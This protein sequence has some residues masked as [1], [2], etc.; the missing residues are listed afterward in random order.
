MN[1][2]RAAILVAAGVLLSACASTIRSDVARFHNL[3]GSSGDSFVIVPKDDD[4]IGGLEFEQYAGLVRGAL[5]DQGYRPAA[6]GTP[7]LLVEVDYFVTE[8][9]EKTRY[10]GPYYPYY[11]HFGFHSRFHHFHHFGYHPFHYG[12]YPSNYSYT[13]YGRQLEVDIVRNNLEREHIFEGTVKSEGR[14]DRLAEVMPFLVQAMF[15]NFPGQ[16]G[17]TERVVIELPN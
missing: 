8:G 16:S 3:S 7:D 1:W 15:T 14:N 6:S 10:S 2:M 4:N 13:V 12:Y 9:R 5:I 17:A 11:G